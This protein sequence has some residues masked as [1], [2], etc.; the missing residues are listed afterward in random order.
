MLVATVLAAMLLG[1]QDA[2]EIRKWIQQL[3]ADYLEE[4]EEAKK[5]LA[6]VGR[7]AEDPLIE[8]L[9]SQDYRV[10]RACLELLVGMKSTKAVKPVAE[11]FRK[12]DEDRTVRQAAFEY[13]CGAGKEA[14]DVLIDA[15]ASEERAF[16]LGAVQKLREMR[17]EK[18]AEKVAELYDREQEKDIKDAAFDCLKNIGKPA[19]PYLV[20]LLASGD[21]SVRNGAID[22]LRNI[23]K[24]S[25]DADVIEKI[26]ALFAAEGDSTVLN[27]AYAFL[28]ECGERAVK[29]FVAGLRGASEGV[30]LKS[31]EGLA[32]L[33]SDAGIEGSAALLERDASDAVRVKAKE[34]LQ[35]FGLR[36]ED[37]FIRALESENARVK[38]LAIEGLGAIKSVKP[39]AK[40]SKLFREDK[41]STVHRTAF[42]YLHRL[43]LPA[44]DDL[45]FALGDPDPAINLEAVKALGV[46]R[47]EKAIPHLLDLLSSLKPEL[48]N[49]AIEA[50]VHI[51]PKA[52]ERVE[53]GRQSGKISRKDADLI[54]GL[55]YQIE[56]ER[57]LVEL[58]SDQGGLGYY[59][60]MFDKVKAFGLARA[61]PVLITI[62][63]DVHYQ[64][65]LSLDREQ[66]ERCAR[67]LRE[68]AILAL[69]ELGNESA[70]EA[71]EE[72]LRATAVG[73]DDDC[74][75]LV[76]ALYRLGAK[77]HLEKYV[78]AMEREA[79]AQ[80]TGEWK[81]DGYNRLF[82]AAMVQARVGLAEAAEK[83]YGNLVSLIE[84]HGKTADL[85]LY[86][87]AL[88]NLAC[89]R[90]MR[91]D[92]KSAV[93]TLR[94]AVVAGFKD[95]GWIRMDRQLDPIRGEDEYKKLIGDDALFKEDRK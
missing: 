45:I 11:I 78:Q 31:L 62:T 19:Q 42:N 30:R 85:S 46:A 15:L 37:H 72:V 18:C 16:R 17:S 10:R 25:K 55:F 34:Y 3:G 49:A 74:A 23:N 47:S 54:V 93:E 28:R 41:D 24:E 81:E 12:A 52:V 88:Y 44:E 32:E 76:V 8:A 83:G 13:L 4:R 84:Q 89:L 60:G 39:L 63:K 14:E 22:G 59:Q 58:I 38:L 57:L 21:A 92:R 53:E 9:A 75:N 95:R 67:G 48:K 79:A 77:K 50:L 2:E 36:S 29:Y 94:R 51:G 69:G 61:I 5:K 35:I 90:A 43:G 40:I 27:N 82:V 7:K 20:K 64:P 80:L 73:P 1:A 33:R 70:V 26:G 68:L 6:A 91:G 56:V 65:R 66:V 86:G 71:L 87:E